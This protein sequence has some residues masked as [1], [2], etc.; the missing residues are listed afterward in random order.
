M[1]NPK[2]PPESP[3]QMT[4]GSQTA[5]NQIATVNNLESAQLTKI[6][7]LE[8]SVTGLASQNDRAFG[9]TAGTHLMVGITTQLMKDLEDVKQI[10]KELN[11]KIDFLKDEISTFNRQNGVLNERVENLKN[12]RHIRNV[13]IAFGTS[14]ITLSPSFS[15]SV[16]FEWLVLPVLIAGAVLVIVGWVS[17][18]KGNN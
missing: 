11:L 17:F 4:D 14:L 8:A 16:E 1:V 18:G 15:T 7:P 3:E 6:A 9:S 5:N 10:N 12:T 13:M 2:T